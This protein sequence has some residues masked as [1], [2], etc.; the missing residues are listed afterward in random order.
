MIRAYNISK[1]GFCEMAITVDHQPTGKTSAELARKEA[2]S[3]FLNFIFIKDYWK[4]SN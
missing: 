2:I 4:L 1:N 3:L